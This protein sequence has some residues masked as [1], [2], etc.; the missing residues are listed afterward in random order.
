M[1]IGLIVNGEL[2][3]R[4]TMT[5]S[6]LFEGSLLSQYVQEGHNLITYPITAGTIQIQ[7][8]TANRSVAAT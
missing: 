1:M 4:I 6:S 5:A 7:S 2:E 8:K 3:K